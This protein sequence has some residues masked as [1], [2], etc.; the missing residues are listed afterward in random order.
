VF[1]D[2]RNYFG[3][4]KIYGTVFKTTLGKSETQP[5]VAVLPEFDTRLMLAD[6]A[7]AIHRPDDARREFEQLERQQPDRP[8]PAESL[9][10]LA[11]QAHDL[12]G[13]R[14]YFE[15]AFAAGESDPQM[16]F[17]L[18]ILERDARQPPEKL[19]PI[20]D[21][22]VR[23]KPDYTDAL[24]QLGLAQVAARQYDSAIGTLLNIQDVKEQRATPLFAG[25]AYA[26]LQTGDLALARKHAETARKWAMTAEETRGLDLLTGLID[27]RFTGPFVP[28]PGEKLQRAEGMVQGVECGP[29]RERLH[30]STENKS[31]VFDMPPVKAVEFTKVSGDGT[32]LRL[33]CGPQK[34]FHAVLDYAP[35]GAAEQGSAGVV[36]RL[37]Y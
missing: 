2:L 6:L 29:G 18:A 22:A 9:G 20:L 32:E 7:V 36:R 31:M 4:K 28:R 37:E 21:R 27:A 25:L 17:Q 33:V 15:R 11:L 16:C 34:P 26:Y 12:E 5:A 8:E 1:D 10:F 13:A 14:H 19:I 23:S 35:A 24:L 3:R 30:L